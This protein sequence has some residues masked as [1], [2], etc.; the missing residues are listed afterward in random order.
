[1]KKKTEETSEMLEF[2]LKLSENGEK[3]VKVCWD[4]G[5]DSGN[6]DL[7]VDGEVRPWEGRAE[8][9]EDVIDL[10]LDDLGYGGFA[11]D[12][13]TEGEVIFDVKKKAFIGQ[14]NYCQSE[15]THISFPDK[16]LKIPILRV[17]VPKDLWFDELNLATQHEDITDVEII[18]K[19]GPVVELHGETEEAIKDY[20]DGWFNEHLY[21]KIRE[22]IDG[23]WNEFSFEYSDFILDQ[24]KEVRY[25]EITGLHYSYRES[26]NKDV[27]IEIE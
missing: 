3:E 25:V 2:L 12:F 20:L 27:Y 17:E 26:D 13:S 15:S 22:D 1:M 16:E 19:N 14:D 10:V 11:G 5:N 18:V 24:K 4:G 6:A 7:Y 8:M 9:E 23:M 21:N